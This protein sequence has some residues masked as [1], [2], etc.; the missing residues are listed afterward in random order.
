M[1]VI[2][3]ALRVYRDASGRDRLLWLLHFAAVPSMLM[4][5]ADLGTD[6]F[7]VLVPH[8]HKAVGLMV[9][10]DAILSGKFDSFTHDATL[11]VQHGFYHLVI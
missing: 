4:S 6:G 10:D 9:S 7:R 11:H 2:Q 5:V 8:L 3:A 1:T